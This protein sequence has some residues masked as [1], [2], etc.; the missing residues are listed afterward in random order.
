MARLGLRSFV[1]LARLAWRIVY[2]SGRRSLTIVVVASLL[3]AVLQGLVVVGLRSLVR[4]TSRLG[5]DVA[6]EPAL[7]AM[8]VV[9][10]LATAGAVV[11]LAA[12]ATQRL[13]G[14]QTTAWTSQLLVRRTATAELIDF[15]LPSFHDQLSRTLIALGSR[16]TLMVNALVG[17]VGGTLGSV[18]LLIAIAAIDRSLAVII[19][20]GLAP[21]WAAATVVARMSARLDRQD[22]ERARQRS[23]LQFLLTS[24]TSAAEQRAFGLSHSLRSRM[25]SLWDQRLTELEGG[26]RRRLLF[27]AIAR[28]VSAAALL[29][30]GYLVLR[31]VRSGTITGAE[32]LVASGAIAVL[33]MRAQDVME[34]VGQLYESAVFLADAESFLGTTSLDEPALEPATVWPSVDVALS[35]VSFRYPSGNRDA[36]TDV[37]IAIK[38][39]EMVALVGPNGCGKTTLALITAGLLSPS[40]GTVTWNG[41]DVSTLDARERQAQAGVL[42]QEFVRYQ[43]TVRDNVLFGDVERPERPDDMTTALGLA[44]TSFLDGLPRG[45]DTGLGPEFTGGTSLSGGQW[46]RLAAARTLYRRSPFLVFDEPTSALDATAE[47]ELFANLRAAFADRAVLVISHRLANLATCDRIYTLDHGRVVDSG[48]HE[49]LIERPGLY[50]TMFRVQAASY[51][52]DHS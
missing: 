31:S 36:V 18:A 43:L 50:Q 9:T 46:Q 16:P 17:F 45:V 4:E 8:V 35:N 5:R 32:G 21:L 27:G 37:S 42:F 29:G 24:R 47:A 33:G 34:S 30:V 14:E 40:S 39:G 52:L 23:Y 25:A 7:R 6:T 44:G 1:R 28:V 2:R 19:V 49:E 48:T 26:L 10:A 11:R 3:A 15:E 38:P 12:A 51:G 41:I 22:T 13:L 20:V